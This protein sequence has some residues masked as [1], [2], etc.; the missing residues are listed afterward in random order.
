VSG[1]WRHL[2]LT[3]SGGRTALYIDGAL[4]HS[5]SGAGGLAAQAPW[6]V[7]RN[8]NLVSFARGLADEVAIYRTALAAATVEEHYR[9][10]APAP[11]S[12]RETV[13]ETP[14]LASYWRLGESSGTTAVDEKGANQGTYQGGVALGQPGAIQGDPDTAAGFDGVDDEVTT[15]GPALTSQG[16]LEGWF[17][18]QAGTA[19]L[20]DNTATPTGWILAYDRS[21]KLAYRIG[22]KTFTTSL[23]VSSVKGA[24]HHYAVTVS[25]GNTSFYLDG[26]LI[27]SGTG[28]GTGQA[29]M[30]WRL[31]HNGGF[32]QFA[33]GL[34]D[35]VAVYEA[36]L[37]AASVQEHYR[38]AGR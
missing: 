29:A 9:A 16:S 3:V 27:H 15:P 21:G 18:W 22:G 30:P 1:A 33:A 12:Y 31:M 34:A 24:W 36:A 11:R 19:L 25:G 4:V 35:E 14:G 13:L 37:S 20:R 5:G 28:A 38:A 26:T 6:H 2:A 17:L 23:D 8:G 10:G 7:M 32:A